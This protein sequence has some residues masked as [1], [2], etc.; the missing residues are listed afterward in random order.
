MQNWNS[1]KQKLPKLQRDILNKISDQSTD[2]LAY[3]KI[4]VLRTL[5]KP[6]E[7]NITENT[8]CGFFKALGGKIISNMFQDWFPPR[9]QRGLL[10]ES[11][12]NLQELECKTKFN[13]W[14]SQQSKRN[15]IVYSLV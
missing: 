2:L 11:S 12:F 1:T 5:Q 7:D 10:S 6:I 8:I 3:K 9:S 14:L 15:H 13:R 4:R